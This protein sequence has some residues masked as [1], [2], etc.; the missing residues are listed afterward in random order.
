MICPP[1]DVASCAALTRLV[2]VQPRRFWAALFCSIKDVVHS[3]SL[4]SPSAPVFITADF[5]SGFLGQFNTVQDEL[6]QHASEPGSSQQGTRK[7]LHWPASGTDRVAVLSS[8]Q[9]DKKTILL[10][11]P[12]RYGQNTRLLRSPANDEQ[13]ALL[14]PSL[15]ARRRPHHSRASHT[16]LSTTSTMR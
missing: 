15:Y 2:D 13:P 14:P 9:T 4:T 8:S 5:S 10:D 16:Q 1:E 6:V 12:C 3:Y 11:E 7:Q